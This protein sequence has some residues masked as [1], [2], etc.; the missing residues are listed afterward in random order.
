MSIEGQHV[1]TQQIG[2]A[3]FLRDARR[4][5]VIDLAGTPITLG[6]DQVS[7]SLIQVT[8]GAAGVVNTPTAAQFVAANKYDFGPFVGAGTDF[9]LRAVGDDITLT[10]A[11]GVTIVGPAVV[12]AGNLAHFLIRLDNV[13]AGAEAVTITNLCCLAS[14]QL[15]LRGAIFGAPITPATAGWPTPLTLPI[16]LTSDLMR[17]GFIQTTGTDTL[18]TDTAVNIIASLPPDLQSEGSFVDVVVYPAAGTA[19][20]TAGTG[21]TING[22]AAFSTTATWRFAVTSPTTVIALRLSVE[23]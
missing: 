22:T 6:I 2:G 5:R 1:R 13:T 19:T 16:V 12:N 23:T 20:L 15:T 17:E 14:G 11:A 8:P 21:V 9:F 10:A 18:T 4:A 3:N 7:R